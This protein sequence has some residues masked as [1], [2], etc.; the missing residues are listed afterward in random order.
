VLKCL[1]QSLAQIPLIDKAL[2]D[3]DQQHNMLAE[4]I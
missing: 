1:E 4:V 3:V 2:D